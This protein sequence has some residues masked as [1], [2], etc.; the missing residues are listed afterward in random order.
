VKVLAAVVTSLVYRRKSFSMLLWQIV[1]AF[2]AA[3]ASCM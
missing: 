1:V 3:K 2:T